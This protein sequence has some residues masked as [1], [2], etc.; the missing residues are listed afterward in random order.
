MN[1]TETMNAADKV[2][3]E[4]YKRFPLVFDKGSGATLW[5]PEGRAYLDFVAGIAVC[6]LG[7][8]HPGV[9]KAVADQ[10]A[11]AINKAQLWEMAVTDSLTGLYVRRYFMVKFQEEIHRAERY[12]KTL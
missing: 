4:T 12:N 7:H 3:A 9:A 8:A 10:A 6:G 1:S 2:I 5:D 11:V